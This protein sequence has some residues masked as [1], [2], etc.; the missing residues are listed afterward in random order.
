M[1]YWDVGNCP[2]LSK[3]AIPKVIG[4]LNSWLWEFEKIRTKDQNI[5]AFYSNFRN[6]NSFCI[7]FLRILAIKCIAYNIKSTIWVQRSA[8][9]KN[10]IF[11][12]SQCV[13]KPKNGH[14]IG[15]AG[16]PRRFHQQFQM[17]TM[18]T[19][20]KTNKLVMKLAIAFSSLFV[21]SE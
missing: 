11:Q 5:Q 8:T 20:K 10:S 19:K 17:M 14:G 6:Q 1:Y 16:N 12:H 21:G 18:K 9:N 4:I 2:S 15:P 13:N 7:R 3:A